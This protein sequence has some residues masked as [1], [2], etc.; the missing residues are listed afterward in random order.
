M[1]I[2]K[3]PKA[4]RKGGCITIGS[5]D[6]IH[7][8]HR[9]IIR[10]V[11]EMAKSRKRPSIIVSFWP[12]PQIVMHKDFP[13]FLT[14][15][16]EKRSLLENLGADFL[17]LMKFTSNL[18]ET[19]AEEFFKNYIYLPL[20]PSGVV[21]GPGHRFG[22]G[23]KGDIKL[24]KRLSK[25]LGFELIAA[26]SYKIGDIPVSSTR[27]REQLLLG[28]VKR[29]NELLGWNYSFRGRVIPGEHRGHKLGFPTV[30]LLPLN[31]EKLLPA[32]GVYAVKVYYKKRVYNG[33]MYMGYKPT[34][35]GEKRSLEVYIFGIR[36]NLYSAILRI[37]FIERLR[38]DE[39]FKDALTLI[40]QIE[41]DV[42]RAKEIL[43][44]S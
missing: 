17:Y 30:N 16:E 4:I 12:L 11:V 6:G 22:K 37:E 19:P 44:K 8:A 15:L 13:F 34:F 24:L 25:D 39:K 32:D 28:N 18:R 3:S 20:K 38:G 42:K 23:R 10:R 27:I 14:T 26:P 40:Q 31:K 7:K 33:V 21:V 5:F 2:V 41:R 43:C 35:G 36:E 29:A 1:Q 9:D